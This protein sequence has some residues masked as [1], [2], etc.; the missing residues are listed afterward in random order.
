MSSPLLK[1]SRNVG[2]YLYTFV[3]FNKCLKIIQLK[4]DEFSMLKTKICSIGECMIEITNTY[5]NNFQQSF[6][7]DTLNFCSY[8]NKKNFNVDYLSSVGK[9][10][11]NKDFF[12][13]L[14]SKKISKKLIHIHPHNET[15]LYLI[16]N[17]KNGE[18]NFYYWRD[19][20]AAKNYLNELNY[21]KLEI[22]LKKY[23]Y[24]Y[25]SGITLSI[26]SKNKQKDFC[27]LIKKLKEYNVKIIFDLNIRIK[28]WPNKKHLNASINLFLPFIDILFS[29]G[30]DIKNWK[31]NDNLSFF[32][33]LIKSNKINH[34]IFRKNASLNYVILDDQIYKVANKVHK[35]IVDSS[36]AGDGYNA[37]YISEFLTSGDVYRSLQASHLLGSKIVMKKGAII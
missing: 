5:N 14:K 10:E 22:I 23:H 30:E 18:K 21:K 28:R 29:T 25:F 27:N 12:N 19:N 15:G 2:D 31:N 26:I 37:A 16:K 20:S 34:A 8:L 36:G 24:I 17:D 35:M 3:Y 1:F 33:K 4:L 13:L 6:A 7:G 9:S 32:N 11:I